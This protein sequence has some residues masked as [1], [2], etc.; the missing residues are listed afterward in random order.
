MLITLPRCCT[1]TASLSNRCDFL[2]SY[3]PNTFSFLLVY[4]LE[5][6][7]HQ[8]F[9]YWFIKNT[10]ILKS[11][12]QTNVSVKQS[13]Q[14]ISSVLCD[15]HSSPDM[16]GGLAKN[17]ISAVAVWIV[18]KLLFVYFALGSNILCCT[19]KPH[20]SSFTPACLKSNTPNVGIQLHENHI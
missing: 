11:H 1:T 5:T 8:S 20:I 10:F 15:L 18:A 19:Y 12:K 3:V 2:G 17:L 4:L 6:T 16:L 7:A 9:C 14:F 13:K